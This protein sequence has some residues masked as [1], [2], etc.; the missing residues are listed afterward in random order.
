MLN[1]DTNTRI[2]LYFFGP[3]SCRHNNGTKFLQLIFYTKHHMLQHSY[4]LATQYHNPVTV[5]K[6]LLLQHTTFIPISHSVS[7]SG[8]CNEA[9]AVCN[10]QHLYQSATQYH[11]PVT[12][13]KQLLSAAH[14]IYTN[15]PLSI[16]IR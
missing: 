12:V 8:D 3:K 1:F 2:D 4:Q 14:N 16:T 6:Q 11:N 13:T 5:T 9:T 10:T 7:Q 15:Q